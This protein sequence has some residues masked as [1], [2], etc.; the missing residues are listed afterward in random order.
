MLVETDAPFLTPHPYRGRPNE[1]Y[2][3]NYT[4]RA[5]A[6]L[7]GVSVEELVVATTETAERT[8]RLGEVAQNRSNQVGAGGTGSL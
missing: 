8:F 4:L 2:C 1:P 7:R 3:A 5:L 6:E